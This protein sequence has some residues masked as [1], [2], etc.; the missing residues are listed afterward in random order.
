MK[1]SYFNFISMILKTLTEDE[2]KSS[3]S[4]FRHDNKTLEIYCKILTNHY[5]SKPSFVEELIKDAKFGS[6]ITIK[7]IID[8]AVAMNFLNKTNFKEDKRKNSLAPTDKMIEEYENYADQ[9]RNA[10]KISKEE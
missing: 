8:D 2:E 6:R 4:F 5:Q 3:L 1:N 10:L 7:K 9:L